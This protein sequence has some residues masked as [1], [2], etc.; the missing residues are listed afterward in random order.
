[1]TFFTP[2]EIE[3]FEG[4]IRTAFLVEMDFVSQKI[5]VWNGTTKLTVNGTEFLPLFGAGSI[6]G[7]SFQNSTVSKSVTFTI[8]GIDDES[9]GLALADPGEMQN[10]LV[11]VYLQMF[12]EDWQQIANPPVI[13]FGYMQP[14]AVEQTE[15]TTDFNADSPTQVIKMSAENIFYNRSKPP[16][17]RYTD[18]DQQLRHPGDEFFKFGPSLVFKVFYYPDV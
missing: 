3:K 5:G 10:R 16:G 17:G 15:V 13:F 9:L 8:S 18:R 1:M 7:L 6:E 2:A 11:K 12:D 4:V 14:P